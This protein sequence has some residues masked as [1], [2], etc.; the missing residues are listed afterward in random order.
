MVL[1]V[2]LI[3]LLLFQ[4][5]GRFRPIDAFP[6]VRLR[7][8]WMDT[9]ATVFEIALLYFCIVLSDP[10]KLSLFGALTTAFIITFR[11]GYYG[12]LIPLQCSCRSRWDLFSGRTTLQNLIKY[13]PEIITIGLI[14]LAVIGAGPLRN[15]RANRR[16]KAPEPD[17]PLSQT[18]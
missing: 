14:L 15:L 3:G 5:L 9:L 7:G 1:R 18:V 10:K 17:S 16:R 12:A 4:V 8:D 13:I 2:V 11:L 6:Y